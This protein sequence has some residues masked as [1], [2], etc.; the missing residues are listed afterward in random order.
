MLNID[1]NSLSNIERHRL[2]EESMNH[3]KLK[4][5]YEKALKAFHS[6]ITNNEELRKAYENFKANLNS[7]LFP[8]EDTLIYTGLDKIG[9]QLHFF[10]YK[11]TNHFISLRIF[12]IFKN[13]FIN[14]DFP[15]REI[16]FRN[17][18]VSNTTFLGWELC[19]SYLFRSK[20]SS[21]RFNFKETFNNKELTLQEKW[22]SGSLV[23]AIDHSSPSFIHQAINFFK[24]DMPEINDHCTISDSVYP[25]N[26]CFFGSG[27]LESNEE[28][29]QILHNGNIQFV[30]SSIYWG[31]MAEDLEINPM[32]HVKNSNSR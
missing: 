28:K 4:I 20:L 32:S 7:T 21:C 24:P 17:I 12:D 1:Y 10:I 8:V 29:Y 27:I 16:P 26:H 30:Q 13:A 19:E 9:G 23:Y 6:C 14:F 5:T 15:Q 11:S 2:S 3:I 22:N 18:S 31:L 25:I